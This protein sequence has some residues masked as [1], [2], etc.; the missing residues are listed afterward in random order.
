MMKSGAPLLVAAI[1]LSPSFLRAAD[2][3]VWTVEEM[4]QAKP[5]SD[6]AV[7]ADGTRVAFV[8]ASPV[9]T[10]EKSEWLSHI[11]LASADGSASEQLT[12]GEQSC[13]S[14]AFS[15]DGNW[16][17]FLSSRGGKEK[18]GGLWRIRTDG[19]EAEPL[20]DEKGS[21]TAFQWSPDGKQIAFLMV[22]PK[23]D[24][25]EKAEKEKRDAIVVDRDYKFSRLYVMPVDVEGKNGKRKSKRLTDGARHLSGERSFDWSPDN[26]AIAFSHTPTPLAD[27]WPKADLSLV[28]VASGKI[29]SLAATRAA[30]ARPS[31]SPDGSLIAY[32]VSDDPPTW[33]GTSHVHL[34]K[35][36]GELVKKLAATHDEKPSII[37]WTADGKRVLIS[38]SYRTVTRLWALPIDGTFAVDI[39]PADLLVTGPAINRKASR[40]AFV[41]EKPDRAAEVFVSGFPAFLPKQISKCQDLPKKPLGKTEVITW[42]S[43]EGREVEGLLTYPVNYNPESKVPLLVVVHGGPAGVFTAGCT[44]S[45]SPYPIAVFASRGYAVLRCN[46]RGSSG[47]GRDFR[48]A[49]Y[50]D[51]GGGDYRDIMSGVDSLIAHGI[52]DPERMGVMGWSY[53]GYMTSWIITQTNRFKAASV[54]AGVTNLM[55][56]TGTAD[57]PS[58]L[59]DYFGGDLWDQ[60]DRWRARSAMFHIKQVTTPTLVQHGD[61]DARVPLSQGQELYQALKRRGV[62]TEMIIYPRQP[63]SIGEPQL[64]LDAMRRNLD[65]F[66]KHLGKG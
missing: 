34:I 28:D 57:I 65:W 31:F 48:Y 51:W 23:T 24:D 1:V 14:P 12:R 47:Y 29:S 18:K 54:G 3:S 44:A 15:P 21:I 19:G 39:S 17:V 38:E 2:E 35:P 8:V 27:D 60:F 22:D 58:F 64:Q 42:K 26:A 41:S 43:S 37:G 62:P 10:G 7:S 25:E 6:P 4:L 56:F 30:E 16:L 40:V 66:E 32:T 52:A 46:V 36:T 61:K 50:Q 45:R 63:H 20:S 33:A 59:P 53:G 49:N 9:M 13:T 11:H 55:S 5:V